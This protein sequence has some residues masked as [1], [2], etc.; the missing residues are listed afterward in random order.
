M[1]AVLDGTRPAWTQRGWD[2]QKPEMREPNEQYKFCGG[3]KVERRSVER[4][5]TLESERDCMVKVNLLERLVRR[6]RQKWTTRSNAA[7]FGNIYEN[8]LWGVG[9]NQKVPFYSGI[10]SYDPSV[11]QYVSL[12]VDVINR[13]DVRNVIEIGCGD[14][15]VASQY[16]DK[17]HNYLGIEVVRALVEHNQRTY[18]TKVV[19]FL[20][21]DASRT[22]LPACDLCII[23]QVL[24]HL[25]NRDV[26]NI[27]Q[28]ITTKYILVTEH[29]PAAHKVT[30]FN[31]DKKPGADI[32]VPRGSG[33]FI[34]KPPFNLSAQVLMEAN[35]TSDIHEADERLVTWLVSR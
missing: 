3:C 18:G 28:N 26:T 11:K 12:V 5:F 29:L 1:L 22:K 24:Q 7:I 32:R 30:F 31:L 20:F 4:R 25:S 16:V 13:Y 19:N 23:R 8:R 9:S 27:F 15:T 33:V 17:C 14:F 2:E 10:G 6:A 21:A 35:V 34:D